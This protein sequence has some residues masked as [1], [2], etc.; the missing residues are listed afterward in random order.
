M[1]EFL[2]QFLKSVNS[3]K[4]SSCILGSNF[5]GGVLMFVGAGEII[6]ANIGM[7]IS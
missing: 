3:Q 7:D 1:V 6:T 4:N 2:I 5:G